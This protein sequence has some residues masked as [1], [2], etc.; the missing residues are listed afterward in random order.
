MAKNRDRQY[1]V[2]VDLGGTFVKFALVADDGELLYRNKLKIGPDCSRDDILERLHNAIQLV[3][4]EAIDRQLAPAGI[5]IG[6]PGIISDGVVLGGADNLNS[7]ENI[8][9][10]AIFSESFNLPVV[11]D[12]DANVVGLAE[13]SFGAA[14]A[15]TDVI[16]VTVGTGIGGAIVVQGELYSGFKNRGTELGH[17]PL[18]HNGLACSCGGRGCLEVYASTTALIESYCQGSGHSAGEL[19]GRYI[20]QKYQEDEALAV[21]CLEEHADYLGHGLAAFVNLFAPQKIVIGGGISEA[22]QFYIN[23]IARATFR[24]AMKACS[25]HTEVVAAD[26]GNWAG[27]L[28]AAALVFRASGQKNKP[29]S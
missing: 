21:K 1:A 20:V 4:D 23:L 24:Y 26:L 12:N 3:V 19:D 25:T 14:K 28:G 5:G 9:L 27:S 29:Q 18:V 2:G 15:C 17:I 8:P 13:V 7:W 11:A 6:T 22:G 16:F 10:Q